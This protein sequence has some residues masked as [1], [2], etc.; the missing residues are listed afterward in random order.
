MSSPAIK[1][2]QVPGG[3][4]SVQATPTKLANDDTPCK[5]IFIQSPAANSIAYWGYDDMTTT[6]QRRG[7]LVGGSAVTI[8]DVCSPSSI[9]IYG[10]AGNGLFWTA[11]RA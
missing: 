11:V 1:G 10:T 6:S 2:S 9:Y 8:T 4:H 7:F 5:S 3:E